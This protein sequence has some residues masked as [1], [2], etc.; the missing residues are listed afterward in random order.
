MSKKQI[1]LI[2]S[3]VL[4]LGTM[5]A[6][7]GHTHSL[8]DEWKADSKSHWKVCEE[9]GETAESGEHTVNDES[10][11]TVC[12]SEIF[13]YGDSVSIFN[14]DEQGNVTRMADYDADGSLI[15]EMVNEYEYDSDGNIIKETQYIDG[16][17]SG[18]AEYSIVEGMSVATKY[19]GY[20]EEGSKFINEYDSAGN[21][22]KMI[23][24]D[25]DGNVELQTDSQYAQ[26]ADGEWYE[27]KCA[28]SYS[29]GTKV[30]CEYNEN[31]DAITR[32]FYDADGNKSETETWEY[33]YNADKV[34]TT[35]KYYIDGVISQEITYKIVTEEDG[36]YS[37]PET[38]AEYDEDGGKTVS[39]Y[40]EN[41]ELVSETKYDTSGNVV[42]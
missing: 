24:Y 16:V 28:E 40:D 42:E 4:V 12:G 30:E 34:K 27:E 5:T 39:V 25:T 21:V 38:I 11:C 36:M 18:E 3:G 1:A 29:D 6:C 19:I 14:Y 41:D 2:V 20:N 15:S 7:S 26:N 13:D 31:G 35:E 23:Y 8:N 9:C 22:I 37:Y 32:V 33:T 17:I 10:I